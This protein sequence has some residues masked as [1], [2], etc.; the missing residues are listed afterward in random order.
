MSARLDI[1]PVTPEIIE[2]VAARL[3][4]GDAAEVLASD[5]HSPLEA[6]RYAARTEYARAALVDGVPMCMWGTQTLRRS[7]IAGTLATVWLLTTDLVDRYPKLFLR[8]CR[9]ELARLLEAEGGRV[10]LVNA[11]DARYT[12][13]LRWARHLG[14]RLREP[15]PFGAGMACWFDVT[16]EDLHV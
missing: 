2:S 12:Q 9:G 5:G 13:A 7:A 10:R 6:C 16:R 14:F 8:G 11:I 3:R 4:P 1:V 15:A